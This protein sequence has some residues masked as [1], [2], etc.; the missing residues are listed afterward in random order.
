VKRSVILLL[1]FFLLPAAL[2]ATSNSTSDGNLIM[3]KVLQSDTVPLRPGSAMVEEG[4]NQA[5]Y[6]ASCRHS[7]DQ[8][9]QN[10]MVVQSEDGRKF[11]IACTIESRWSNCIPLPV[12]DSFRAR[13]EKNDLQVVYLGSNGRPRK[14][15]YR[16][17][18]D[19][20]LAA[21]T[22]SR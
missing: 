3:I 15:R 17:V 11:S 4:C 13:I 12:G 5:D 22:A 14:Q 1:F 2:L 7:S 6:S 8:Y 10:V 19:A 21:P 18:P 20:S 16:V 9:V